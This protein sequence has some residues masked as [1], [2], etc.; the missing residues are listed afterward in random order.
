[1]KTLYPLLL[2][3]L[4]ICNSFGQSYHALPGKL[5]AEN[6]T[7]IHGVP[8]ETCEDQGGGLDVGWMGDDSYADY[9]V[10]VPQA[11]IYSFNFRIANGFSDDAQLQLLTASGAVVTNIILPRTGGMQ[12]WTTVKTT[13]FL[14]AGNQ[15]V[16]ILAKK[17]KRCFRT[18]L[19]LCIRI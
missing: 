13:G 2:V 15:T 19:V 5:E 10:S 18:Q 1:M 6:Y 3:I 16:R 12:Y 9:N 14:S 4:F 11:G 8:T 17:Q 7:T